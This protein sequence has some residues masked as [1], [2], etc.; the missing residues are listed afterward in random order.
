MPATTPITGVMDG[1][2]TT[3]GI[4]KNS[5]ISTEPIAPLSLTMM[6]GNHTLFSTD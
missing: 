3:R 2:F 1:L 5:A 4:P 6:S